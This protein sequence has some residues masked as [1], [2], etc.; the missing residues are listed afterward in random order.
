M[1]TVQSESR[2]AARWE[3]PP[4]GAR[5]T[6]HMPHTRANSN[7]CD[8][9][10]Y[11]RGTLHKRS[12]D[13][14]RAC[15]AVTTCARTTRIAADVHVPAKQPRHA[16]ASKLHAQQRRGEREEDNVA[17]AAVAGQADS[18]ELDL[19]AHALVQEWTAQDDMED[20]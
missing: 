4:G 19:E 16:A 9:S 1:Y 12:I 15:D 6:S 17:A 11:E 2:R 18:A 10:V 20:H 7:R 5:A 13:N 3:T 14:T 8:E